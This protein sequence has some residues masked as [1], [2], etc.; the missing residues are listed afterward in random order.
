[1]RS[2]HS[3]DIECYRDRSADVLRHYG[4]Y[5][6]HTCGRFIVTLGPVPTPLVVIAASDEGWDH[7]SVSAPGRVPTWAE[8]ELVKRHFFQPEETAMQL[9]VPPSEHINCHPYTLHLWR[10]H[11]QPI[12]RPPGHMV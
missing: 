4:N 6:D 7:V 5:G 12:P 8:M 1:M 11:A 3:F 2:L 9:H 10:P